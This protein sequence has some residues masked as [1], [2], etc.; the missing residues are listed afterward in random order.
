VVGV[1][2][3]AFEPPSEGA[4][5]GAAAPSPEDGDDDGVLSAMLPDGE[6]ERESVL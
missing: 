2:S 3:L 1:A 6:E 4:G 5:A